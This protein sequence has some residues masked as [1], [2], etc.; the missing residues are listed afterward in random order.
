MTDA[1]PA[2]RPKA[3]KPRGFPD[4]RVETLALE[5]RIIAIAGGV[6]ERW[7]FDRLETGAFEYADCLGKFLPDQDRPN[8]GVFSVE[9]D[10]KQ[11]MALRYDL[12]APLAR[13]VA[14]NHDKVPRPFRRWAAGP[15][16]R[17]EKPGPGRFREFLQC[18]ADSVGAPGPAADA[19]MIAM[20]LEAL[21]AIGLPEDA[22]AVK[23][24]T[25]KAL[26]AVLDQA[27]G[28]DS[29]ARLV[30]L[31][32]IDKLDRLGEAGVAQL[33]GPGRK[34]DSGDFTKGAGLPDD[35]IALILGFLNAG[36]GDRTA[37]IAQLAP[38]L[39]G[40]A[41]G[42]AALADLAAIDAVLTALGVTGARAPIDP[43][44]VRGLEYY[45]GAVFEAQA[46][47]PPSGADGAAVQVGSI[48]GGGRYDD[49]VARFRGEKLP[50]TGFS[51][52][53]SRLATLLA[54]HHAAPQIGPVVVLPLEPSLTADGF[55]LAAQL[56]AAGMRAEV[57][58]GGA[59]MK[60]Q[61]KY[62]D[63]R[64]APAALMLGSDEAARGVVSVKDLALGAALAKNIA[65]NEEWR[66]GQPAQTEVARADIVAAVAAILARSGA[67]P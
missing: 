41:D 60:A 33:L 19:E 21:A 46:A 11:W 57:Y 66:K 3:R 23:I 27:G 16:W 48:G 44:I 51:I 18:D 5:Q 65:S 10:D 38:L 40:H 47:L 58:L 45:T 17:N 8:E 29:Q 63:R 39:A 56:R 20:A 28:A 42:E 30:I 35:K 64:N 31:R 43:S 59:G 36:R 15:V 54:L 52:G 12:T 14:E 2:F 1:S 9:D 7:G 6:Y 26:N 34:D 67:A 62:A 13:F 50:A 22:V 61:L 25:R 24:N 32:A 55:L 4:R 49:L 53:V 37:S